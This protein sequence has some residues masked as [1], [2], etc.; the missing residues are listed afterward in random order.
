MS[1]ETQARILSPDTKRGNRIPPGQTETK[2]WPVLHHGTV[3]QVD[4]DK[5]TFKADGLVKQSIELSHEEFTSLPMIEVSA[6]MHCVTTWSRLDN[7]WEGVSIHEIIKRVEPKPEAQ[8]VIIHAEH[9][10]TTNLPLFD[11]VQDDVLFAWKNN[12]QD[13]TPE[14]GWPLRLVVPRLYAWKSAKW[15]RRIEFTDQD[16]PGFW[17]SVGYHMRG[18]PWKEERFQNYC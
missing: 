15:V 11:L 6:D 7:V 3:P 10:W 9:G 2:K 8:F 16:K 5:W 17:E 14:H 1:Q 12:G 4:L 18:N 13:M